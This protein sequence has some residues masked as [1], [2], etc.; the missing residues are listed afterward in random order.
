MLLTSFVGKICY[1]DEWWTVCIWR[2]L[3]NIEIGWRIGARIQ[4]FPIFFFL[5]DVFRVFFFWL[6]CSFLVSQLFSCSPSQP[7]CYEIFLLL[8]PVTGDQVVA[9]N[10]QMKAERCVWWNPLQFRLRTLTTQSRVLMYW[11]IENTMV[12]L[13]EGLYQFFKESHYWSSGQDKI[14]VFGLFSLMRT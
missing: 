7:P 2:W 4:N 14:P 11:N 3:D 6:L 5:L 1:E 12:S 10:P 13:L 8:L 9:T